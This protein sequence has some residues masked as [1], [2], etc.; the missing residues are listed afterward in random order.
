MSS[1]IPPL[2]A[3][4]I[5]LVASEVPARASVEPFASGQ[6]G[7]IQRPPTILEV[8]RRQV[9]PDL[10]VGS[11]HVFDLHSAVEAVEFDLSGVDDLPVDPNAAIYCSGSSERRLNDAFN[12]THT[13][14]LAQ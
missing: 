2:A 3:S 10:I 7:F 5:S 13:T 8:A 9:G 11:V 4:L 14:L 12:F 6:F 1:A